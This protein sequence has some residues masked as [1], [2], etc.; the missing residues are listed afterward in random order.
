MASPLKSDLFNPAGPPPLD[1]VHPSTILPGYEWRTAAGF[2]L[3]LVSNGGHIWS[4][5]SQVFSHLYSDKKGGHL[6]HLM[7]IDGPVWKTVPKLVAACFLPNDDVRYTHVAHRNKVR[8]DNRAENLYWVTRKE[9]TA[10][11]V[12]AA[13]ARQNEPRGETPSHLG[14]DD[15]LSIYEAAEQGVSATAL[16]R[17]LGVSHS[18]IL[19]V[20]RGDTHRHLFNKYHTPQ[21]EA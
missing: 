8:T 16:G 6:V 5:K 2:P 12:A 7:T 17:V 15:V 11:I 21:S 18:A 9:L 14:D 4:I 19:S 10:E 1:S 3:Y 20:L 13:I